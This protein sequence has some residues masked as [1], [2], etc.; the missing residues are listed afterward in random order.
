MKKEHEILFTPFKIGSVELKNRYVMGPMGVPAA[1]DS[2]GALS[3]TGIDYWVERAKGGFGMMYTGVM[4]VDY[5][6]ETPMGP[7]PL[8]NPM[9]F[10]SR[11]LLLN[12]RCDAY[13]AKIFAE[14]GMGM[15]RNYPGGMAPS[16]VEVF[17]FPQFKGIPL[18][19][20]QIHI[21]RDEMIEAAALMQQSG[22]AG[23]DIH[24]IHWGY[25]I[26]EF[27]LAI[28]NHREDE[29]GG[30]RE[31]RM[32]IVK[33]IIEGI[34]QTCGP[35]FPV[36]I[37]LGVKSFIKA[38]N[39]ASLT[40]EEEAGRTVEESVKIVKM[41]EG[42]GFDAIMTDT[43]TYDSF[44]Y[45]CP[46]I[47]MPKGHGIDLYGPIKDAVN[48]P[49]LFRS[50]M[51]DPDMCAAVVREGKADAVVLARPS[52]A[53][54]Y[55]PQKVETGKIDKIR[56]CIGCNIGCIGALGETGAPVSCAVNP[57][58]LRERETLP[59]KALC[60]KK[61]M[62]VGGGIA[63]MEAACTAKRCGHDVELYEKSDILGGE[64]I[65]AGAHDFKPEMNQ[66]TEWYRGEIRDLEVPVH[67]G[68][69]VTADLVMQAAPDA[70]ILALGASPVVPKSL[71]GTD[72]PNVMTGVDALTNHAK[73][74]GHVV[75]VGAGQV[76]AETAVD[77]AR[78]GCKVTMIDALPGI[79]STGFVPCQ[80]K[81]MLTD[82]LEHYGVEVR[83]STKLAEIQADGVVVE[84]A[85]G[86][87]QE[88]IPA[89]HVLLCIGLKP[90]A[91]LRPALV[92]R[93]CDAAIYEIGSG[94][95]N[96]NV[97]N[98]VHEAF[99]VAYSL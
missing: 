87:A 52:L 11:A 41:L 45:A 29:Y 94:R 42:M 36:T 60:P 3:D 8:Q 20:D 38:L 63:G 89:D 18:T 17:N 44:Y 40:G 9:G 69:E 92:E 77:Y 65:P 78:Q 23:V 5:K 70:V 21:K 76:G 31:N 99:E 34:R 28:T 14:I 93:G 39:K 79:L 48:I 75:V 62:V 47:Y 57:R 19:V 82:M 85:E 56:P 27:V 54:P 58:T 59:K 1:Y 7:T 35:N 33:E 13:G 24:T 16:D 95:K 4:L 6:V 30:T 10:R 73:L 61:V 72:L 90:N 91:S 50:K 81:M 22:F 53:D 64:M 15:G 49:V 43:G 84:P 88:K 46:P 25:L 68:C 83:T 98:A 37:G 32:R 55:L 2:T 74:A 86:G 66:L 12:E 26:D 67:L 51:G 96:G 80:H 71:K 97:L